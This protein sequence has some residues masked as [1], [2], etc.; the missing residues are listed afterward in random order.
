M[1]ILYQNNQFCNKPVQPT[2][3]TAGS[4]LM[5]NQCS[6]TDASI[7]IH[8]EVAQLPKR[9]ERRLLLR[10]R[11]AKVRKKL[12]ENDEKNKSTMKYSSAIGVLKSECFTVAVN[13]SEM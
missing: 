9:R 12:G 13:N 10:E 7:S 5:T 6:L 4:G 8:T 1:C 3:E 11:W 2:K